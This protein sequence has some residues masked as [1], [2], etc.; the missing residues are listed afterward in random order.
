MCERE[1]SAVAV[2]ADADAARWLVVVGPWWFHLLVDHH[3]QQHRGKVGLTWYDLFDRHPRYDDD[4]GD[5]FVMMKP[6]MFVAKMVDPHHRLDP[7]AVAVDQ[8]TWRWT[9]L[10]LS[11]VSHHDST[12]SKTPWRMKQQTTKVFVAAAAAL[13]ER[14][15]ELHVGQP[16]AY[17]CRCHPRRNF[18]YVI[19]V[20]LLA[21]PRLLLRRH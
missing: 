17:R 1:S 12:S 15:L 6:M 3:Q 20:T 16:P 5:V 14:E 8:P 4:D 11:S 21:V 13:A 19:G 10:L 7:A 2:P 18:G 9:Y